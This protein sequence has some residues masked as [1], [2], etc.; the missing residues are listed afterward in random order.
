[1]TLTQPRLS[2]NARFPSGERRFARE[3]IKTLSA[4]LP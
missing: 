4:R 1:M 3:P 2:E